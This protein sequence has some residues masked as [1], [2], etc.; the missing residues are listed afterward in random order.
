[1]TIQRTLAD[2]APLE[3]ALARLRAVLADR[4]SVDEIALVA[5]DGEGLVVAGGE[6]VAEGSLVARVLDTGEPEP[7]QPVHKG[8]MPL[9]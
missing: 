1:M 2:E 5:R 3:L 6:R 4:L 7:D 9:G 8:G